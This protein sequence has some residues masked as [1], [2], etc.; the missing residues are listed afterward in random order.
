LV[1]LAPLIVMFLTSLKRESEVLNPAS[2]LPKEIR[3]DNY[4]QIM[5][6]AVE[7]PIGAWLL[8]SIFVSCTVT[9]AV[10]VLSSMAAFALTR[11]TV[12][13]GRFIFNLI[14][15]SMMLPTQL[16]LIP[17]Y[18]ILSRMH[19]IDT[20]G[21]LILP[22]VAG[23]FGV[24]MLSQFMRSIP[25]AVEEAALIDGC[26]L[27]QVYWNVCLPLCGPAIATLAVFTFIGSWNDY[28]SPL[29]FMDSVTNYTLPVGIAL[30]QSSYST[31]YGLTLATSVL[32]TLPLMLV[33]F[34]FQKQIIESMASS[35]LKD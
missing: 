10:L 28:V 2:V 17:L 27:W 35:G 4:R 32:A 7:A 9:L 29:V 20:P 26:S 14:V 15:G 24:F 19:L 16:F 12:P 34:G 1:F 8:N 30:F 23:G 22:A 3:T 18:M 13:G 5:G 21:A 6:N 31:Q 33:F 11:L 25:P